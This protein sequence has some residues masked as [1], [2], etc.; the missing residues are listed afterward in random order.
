MAQ[1]IKITSDRLRLAFVWALALTLLYLSSGYSYP[2]FHT[3]AEVFSISVAFAVFMLVWS[4]KKYLEDGFLKLIGT[5][6]LFVGIVDILHTLAYKGMGIFQGYD[7]NLSAQLWIAGRYLQAL[8]ILLA[9][10]FVG[11]KK[12]GWGLAFT[13]YSI[14]TIS[15]LSAVFAG[16]FPDCFIEGKGL[17]PFK[18]ISEYL[19][20]AILAASAFLLYRKRD[21]FD[22][23]VYLFLVSSIAFTIGAELMFTFYISVYGISNLV[24]HF[25]KI[26]AFYAVYKAIIETGLARPFDLL[27]RDLNIAKEELQTHRD[28]LEETVI[29]RTAELSYVNEQL[30]KEINQRI[31]SEK[32]LRKL[33]EDLDLEMEFRMKAEKELRTVLDGLE[34]KVAE[35]TS[36]LE[37]IN[38]EL[39][40]F[41]YIVSH[42][43]K[44]PLRSIS[45]LASWVAEDY[46]EKLGGEGKEQLE[47]LVGK[48]KRMHSLIDAILGY[49]RISRTIDD[50]ALV[51]MAELA[52]RAIEILSPP[53]NIGIHVGALPFVH[54]D[55][56][57]MEQV[58][59]N[60]I[61]NAIKFMDKP[62]GE[63]RVSC[64]VE[65]GFYRFGV[66]DNGP[67]IERRHFE[68]IFKM[69]QTLSPQ[70]DSES[71][72]V[73]LAIVRKIIEMHGG[74]IWV[75]SEL[76]MGSSFYFTLPIDEN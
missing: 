25:F 46:G 42:D 61:S 37:S 12:F 26:L 64:S 35:R 47:M 17:T 32:E 76:G 72:G 39:N 22:R 5:S 63:I 7:A 3:L 1:L 69:F 45:S 33:N 50:K 67:G 18:K 52:N 14:V 58:F 8:S 60:L 74:R 16:A 20:S 21:V 31:N 15:L 62:E 19:I 75:E 30:I 11:R 43:L 34:A 6:F 38:R 24:G 40:D 48:A 10:F 4:S 28:S 13:L 29:E 66:S 49:S 9:T 2:L 65:N 68:R 53:S 36:E 56:T 44:A 23:K 73:G 70:E 55:R 57:R 71:T 51:D 54:G 27:F 59:M 41:A